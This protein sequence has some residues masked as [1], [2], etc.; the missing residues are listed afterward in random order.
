MLHLDVLQ[1]QW[2][3]LALFGGLA[4]AL[5]ITL[6]YLAFWRVSEPPAEGSP[7]ARPQGRV[8]WVLIVLYAVIV[9]YAVGYLVMKAMNPPTW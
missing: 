2:V 7:A 6:A 9:V 1:N 5:V 3:I 8:P 4:G